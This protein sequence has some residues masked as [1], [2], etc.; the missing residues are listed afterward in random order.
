MNTAFCV[1]S[2]DTS[3]TLWYFPEDFYGVRCL[4]LRISEVF[5]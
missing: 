1:I 5:R 2:L 3:A 4:K